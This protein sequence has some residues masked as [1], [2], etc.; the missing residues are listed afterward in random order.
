V[1]GDNIIRLWRRRSRLD[2]AELDLYTD[3]LPLIDVEVLDR[4]ENLPLE[5]R[6]N[7]YNCFINNE[8]TPMELLLIELLLMLPEKERKRWLLKNRQKRSG[9]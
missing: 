2:N 1:I 8:G 4:F 7:V 3:M 9:L 6:M 5:R